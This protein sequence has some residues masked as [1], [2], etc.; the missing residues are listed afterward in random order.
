MSHL[1]IP[2]VDEATLARLRDRAARHGR[3]AETEA[4]AI[5]ADALPPVPAPKWA[6]VNALRDQLAASGRRFPDSTELIS[7]DR[8]R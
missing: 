8:D 5:L 4:K 6:A 3:T 2:D 1:L 7:K